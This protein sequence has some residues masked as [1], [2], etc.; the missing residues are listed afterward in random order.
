MANP[1]FLFRRDC[2]SISA[3]YATSGNT[4]WSELIETPPPLSEQFLQFIHCVAWP[5]RFFL[6]F[7]PAPFFLFT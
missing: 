4:T 6:C 3:Y 1:S 2:I 5:V 7:F